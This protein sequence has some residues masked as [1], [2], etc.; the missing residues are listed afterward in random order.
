ALIRELYANA[1]T[2]LS[3]NGNILPLKTNKP[4]KVATVAINKKESTIFQKRINSYYP[5][6]NFHVDTE[7]IKSVAEISEKLRDFD[8]VIAAVYLND[9]RPGRNFGIKPGMTGF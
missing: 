6:E 9:Q 3:N 1:I 8:I 2:L 5:A 7:D 4:L